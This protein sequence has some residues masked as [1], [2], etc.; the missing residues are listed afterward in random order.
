MKLFVKRLLAFFPFGIIA[1]SFILLT[2]S[3][4]IPFEAFNKNL[5]YK[6]GSYGHLHSRIQEI[7]SIGEVDILVV[8][9]SHAYRGFDPR[10]FDRYEIDL[11]NLGSSN[12]TPKQ[13]YV[14]LESYL[15][16][17]NPSLVIYEVYPGIFQQDGLE[18][19]LDIV[20][21]GPLNQ[22]VVEMA[23][24]STSI[25]AFN[26][27]LNRFF[28]QG[29]GGYKSYSEPLR[30]LKDHDT[31][32]SRGYVQKDGNYLRNQNLEDSYSW[33]VR[34]D[35]WNYLISIK[36]MLAGRGVDFLMVQSPIDSA[37]FK[38][39]VNNE[40]VDRRLRSIGNYVNFNYVLSLHYGEDLYD[41]HHLRQTGVEKFN[42]QLIELLREKDYLK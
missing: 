37:Y 14:L 41:L 30:K 13:S 24:K 39:I 1:Y 32:V 12:Q 26:A 22:A 18:S 6:M 19:T 7:D 11:F 33:N 10:I 23:L 35:Q 42:H 3:N 27:L 40:E 31:Y 8:G 20:A 28:I 17:F 9:S 25:K 16:T 36:E 5:N 21:N 2:W 38:R 15:D 29:T 4:L 34:E